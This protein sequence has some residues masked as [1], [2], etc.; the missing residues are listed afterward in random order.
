[1]SGNNCDIEGFIELLSHLADQKNQ[2]NFLMPFI[3]ARGIKYNKNTKV[4]TD[5]ILGFKHLVNGIEKSDDT[6]HETATEYSA[7]FKTINLTSYRRYASTK[8]VQFPLPNTTEFP[9]NRHPHK[10]YDINAHIEFIKKKF[11]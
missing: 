1:M 11:A 3:D 10:I 8:L 2:E 9:R 5:M 6:F 4:F 7:M